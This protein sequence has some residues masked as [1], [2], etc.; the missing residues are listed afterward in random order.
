MQSLLK[1]NATQ[2]QRVWPLQLDSDEA[3]PSSEGTPR[4]GGDAVDL[5]REMAG[6]YAKQ[7]PHAVSG[8]LRKKVRLWR[9]SPA[10]EVCCVSI[11]NKSSSP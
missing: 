3:L 2:Q 8:D 9:V 1:N 11:V 7:P 4:V 10:S 6:L 5:Y